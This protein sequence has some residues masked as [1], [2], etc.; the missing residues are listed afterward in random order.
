MP[1]YSEENNGYGNKA[2]NETEI[3]QPESKTQFDAMM[4]KGYEEAQAGIGL[5]VDEAF[6]MINDVI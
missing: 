5:S 6:K 3:V 2:I 4:Q 1:T